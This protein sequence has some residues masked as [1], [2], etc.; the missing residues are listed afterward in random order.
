MEDNNILQVKSGEPRSELQQAY[1]QI[2][3]LEAKV[4]NLELKNAELKAKI[5]CLRYD[6]N[7]INDIIFGEEK[8]YP[9]D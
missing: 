1:D 4:E 5:W 7:E 9:D 6:I 2:A 3:V 8:E